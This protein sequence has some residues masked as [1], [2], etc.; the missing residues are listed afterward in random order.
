M[1][2]TNEIK[3]WRFLYSFQSLKTHNNPCQNTIWRH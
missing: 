1:N 2:Q 3:R